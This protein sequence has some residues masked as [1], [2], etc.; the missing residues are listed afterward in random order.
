[1]S[2]VAFLVSHPQATVLMQPTVRPLDDPAVA[3]QPAAMGRI[4]AGQVGANATAPQRL[5]MRLGMIRPVGI[6]GVTLSGGQRQR[7]CI[8][9]AFIADPAILLLDEATAAVEPE[10]EILIQSAL[11][12]L[13][14]GRTTIIVSHRLS[15][16]RDADVILV[17]NRGRLIERGTHQ[18]LM[19]HDGWYARMYRLQMGEG[20]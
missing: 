5:A 12:R 20:L 3:S 7:L 16:V 19:A 11:Q 1:M 8:A 4:A 10:S 2:V 13:M 17:L 6:R 18:Q 15:M 9:R 14:K